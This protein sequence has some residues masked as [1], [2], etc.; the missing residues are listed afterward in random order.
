MEKPNRTRR[1]VLA[2]TGTVTLAGIGLGSAGSVLADSDSEQEY[3]H[4]WDGQKGSENAEQDCGTDE[5]G[6]WHWIL[7]SSGP[8]SFD[9]GAEL[10]V[11]FA[12]DTTKTAD[13]YRPGGE[14]GAVHF[15][16]TKGDGGT[17]TAASVTYSGVDGDVR[18]TISDGECR[19]MADDGD[20]MSDGNDD[21]SDGDDEMPEEPPEEYEDLT[22]TDECLHGDGMM[23]VSNGNEI[24]ASV[25]VSGP[26]GYECEKEV[27]AGGAAEF[28]GLANGTYDLQTSADGIGFDQSCVEIDY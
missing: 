18:L 23:T 19:D 22:V 27:P 24:S 21:M 11:E 13:E 25:T 7:N 6:F 8:S 9:V 5:Q 3:S 20:D 4:E 17:V 14:N 1:D 12:D 15:D 16:M 26:N 10:T 28:S 2:L